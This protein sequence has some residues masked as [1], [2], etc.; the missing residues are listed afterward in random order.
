MKNGAVARPAVLPLPF[1]AVRTQGQ[2]RACGACC[3]ARLHT[4]DL[5]CLACGR[6]A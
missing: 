5:L 4:S 6:R 2:C 1:L 3:L